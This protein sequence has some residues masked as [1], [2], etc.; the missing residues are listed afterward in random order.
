MAA[1]RG[2]HA[3]LPS[4]TVLNNRYKVVKECGCGNFS[5]VFHCIDTQNENQPVAVKLLKREYASDA[6]FERDI[7]KAVGSHDRSKN[8]K[9]TR[10]LDYFVHN[11]FPTFVFPLAGPSLRSCKLGVTRGHVSNQEMKNFAMQMLQALDFLHRDVKMVHTDLKPENILLDSALAKDSNGIGH[12]WT[13]CDFGSASFL[14]PDRL[15]SDLISTRP[16]RAPEVVLG[17]GWSTSADVW[18][19][20]CVLFEVQAGSRLFEVHD[21]AEHLH[22]FEGRLGAKLPSSFTKH[23]KN[24]GRFFN[25]DGSHRRPSLKTVRSMSEVLKENQEFLDLLRAMLELEPKR[26][27]SAS[28]ALK[29]P[30]FRDLVQ[31]T[32]SSS[33]TDE[34]AAPTLKRKASSPPKPTPDAAALPLRERSSSSDNAAKQKDATTIHPVLAAREAAKL[35]AGQMLSRQLPAAGR[36][37]YAARQPPYAVGRFY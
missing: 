10:M 29:H 28:E 20:A 14:R 25:H 2:E 34:A 13:V 5:K 6:A 32:E 15:D 7:L 19:M 21:D 1:S 9:V 26:R 30:Y 16:Y 4:G 17:N 11:R 36:P 35:K 27:I 3:N 23:S 33:S 37:S 24:S 8:Q 31:R 18:S 22:A 12:G